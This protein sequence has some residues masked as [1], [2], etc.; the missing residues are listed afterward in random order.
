MNILNVSFLQNYTFFFVELYTNHC[1]SC[2]TARRRRIFLQ[3][4]IYRIDFASKFIVF[5]RSESSKLSSKSIPL[6][7]PQQFYI[8]FNILLNSTFFAEFSKPK[9]ST[10]F[11]R[12]FQTPD[13]TI[14]HFFCRKKTSD[15]AGTAVTRGVLDYISVSG[16]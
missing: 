11:C 12:I 7:R 5:R 1:S 9:N 6:V 14:L 10:F 4:V 3:L 8:L 15:W 16:A 13:S 2:T